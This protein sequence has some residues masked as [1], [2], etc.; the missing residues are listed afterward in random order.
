L[1][2]EALWEGIYVFSKTGTNT[3]YPISGYLAALDS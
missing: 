3:F 2:E 1:A